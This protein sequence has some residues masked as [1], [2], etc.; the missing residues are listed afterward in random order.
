MDELTEVTHRARDIEDTDGLTANYEFYCFHV[1]EFR[2]GA[3]CSP[4][5][6]LPAIHRAAQRLRHHHRR[7]RHRRRRPRR[8]SCRPPRR[9]QAHP[10]AGSWFVHLS[11]ARLQHLSFLER[12]PREA[13]GCD[14]FWQSGNRHA[15]LH[16][17]EAAAELRR[18]LDLLVRA[19]PVHSGVGAGL[20]SAARPAGPGERPAEAG[21][22]DD[23]RV[24]LDGNDRPEQS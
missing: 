1:R 21:G 12:E 16:R 20:L 14:T 10:G 15:E 24:A 6:S 18:P 11:D 2:L 19:D 13:F 22:R 17:R 5:A 8:R 3:D 9:T 4:G 7:L 23:E